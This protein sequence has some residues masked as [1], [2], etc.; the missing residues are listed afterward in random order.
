MSRVKI[1]LFLLVSLKLSWAQTNVYRDTI[2]VYESGSRLLMPWA[3]GINFSS[4]T[5]IDLNGDGKKDIVAYD[6]IGGSGGRLRAYLNVG[7]V[8]ETKYKHDFT[9]QEQFPA[10]TDWALFFDYDF[11]GKADL[12]TYTTGGVKVFK[13]STVGQN[14]VFTL[15]K[16]LIK[17]DYNPFGAPSLSNL[18]VSSVG[19]P[20]IA[21]LDNDGDLD[22]LTFSVVGTT[23]EYHKNMS[24]ELY[25][26]AD[27]L[28]F[29][30]VDL[31]W[32]D[33]H[34]GGCQLD[35]NYCPYMKMFQASMQNN[36]DK[37]LHSGSCIMCFDRDGDGD[38]E[39]I[40]GDISCANVFFAE[41]VGTTSNN[42]IGDT[43]V[44]YPNY[45]NKAS[46]NV[47]KL[48]S[49]PCTYYL[50][51]DNDAVSDLI[52]SPNAISG[53]ENYQS[54][55]YY[56]NASTTSTVNFVFQKKNF[57][58]EDMI[59]LG[60]GAYPVLFDADA[61]GK[62]DLIVGNLG[63]YIVNTNKAR[64]AY[65]K[66]IGTNSSPSFSLIT[67]DYQSLS[68]YNLF[69]MAP[70]FG[71][72]NGDGDLDLIVG[73]TN[74]R[75]HY[76]ENTAGAGNPAVFGN[77]VA[78]YQNILGS[79]F[80]YPQLYDV[81][82]NGTLD[83]LLGSQ[84]GKLTYYKNVGTTAS[85]T[86]SF[87]TGFFGSVDVKQYGWTTGFSMPFMYSEAGVT[88]LLIGS[89]VGNIYLYDNIDGNLTGAFNRVDTTLF[90]VNEG[91]RCAPFFEDITGD[92]KRDLF[93]GNYAGGLAFFN[94]TNVNQVG[95]KELF[96]DENVIV[97]PNPASDKITVSIN[98]ASYQEITIKCY[99]MLG[100][101]VFE[102]NTFN[103][104]V[105][106]DVSQFSKGVYMVKLQCKDSNQF[107]V[108]TKKVIVSH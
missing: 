64:L 50:D 15:V 61:D 68:T 108:V 81:D 106:I 33:I 45:P 17:S 98:D 105:D 46:T 97:F 52:A 107:K 44:L 103:K 13:N 53:A 66:N 11:D 21:D 69:S 39:L 20:G 65:Y 104:W 48:N 41:N 54:V 71:D 80:V 78:N 93:V 32:G 23:V 91:P 14:L 73:S 87:V 86:F 88:K 2:P 10:V 8:G 27:S 6:K 84:N 18:P 67:R 3:G 24:Q 58:Q 30:M 47:I 62:K 40:M 34:E 95:V 101:I 29:D 75:V 4:F 76:F 1:I 82:K 38:K 60:E 57:L 85:P 43:T 56:K 77:Y 26:N 99:D 42:H 37:V 16:S 100:K 89:E 79:N 70:T 28:V 59:E 92:G 25:G 36:V 22:I 63:Y 94:S 31:C 72:L 55:W 102:K 90:H 74:G 7:G 5:N 19:I 9:H 35:L 12:F 83:L 96:N 49:F 51:V